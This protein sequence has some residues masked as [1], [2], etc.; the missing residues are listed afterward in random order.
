MKTIYLD[1]DFRCYVNNNDTVIAIETDF[2]DGKCDEYIEGHIF[3]PEGYP[4]TRSDGKIFYNGMV[5]KW[6]DHN[7]LEKKQ[8]IYEMDLLKLELEQIQVK[9]VKYENQQEELNTSYQEGINSI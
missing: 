7:E 8:Q 1:S 4:W 6:Q 3:V 9:I 2:F 5:R